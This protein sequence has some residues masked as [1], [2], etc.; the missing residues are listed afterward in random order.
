MKNIQ[1]INGL[2]LFYTPSPALWA[3]S[4]SRARWTTHGFTLIELLVV[5]LIIGI[6][7]A[8]AVPQYQFAVMKSRVAAIQPILDSI[9]QAEEAYYLANGAYANSIENLDIDLT[10]CS[11][12][13]TYGSIKICGDWMIDL[14]S[15]EAGLNANKIRGA[16]CP[17]EI[18]STKKWDQCAYST[19]NFMITV[20]LNHSPYPNK[21]TCDYA[22]TP[23]GQ[24]ICNWINNQ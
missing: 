17:N 19:G 15:G 14:I 1:H 24:K 21:I 5:V 3:S 23:I 6:L 11:N 4:P 10:Q 13:Q 22:L 12:E 2:T 16:Y 20:W 9:K 8:I 18:K 7:A